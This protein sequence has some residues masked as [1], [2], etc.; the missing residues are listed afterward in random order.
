MKESILA[1]IQGEFGERELPE[2]GTV[3][4]DTYTVILCPVCN[5][6]TLDNYDICRYCGWEY[7]GF[8]ENHFP[9]ANGAALRDYREAYKKMMTAKKVFVGGSKSLSVLTQVERE[10]LFTYVHDECGDL[11]PRSHR[12][13][14][15]KRFSEKHGGDQLL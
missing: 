3:I 13:A 6:K 2:V 15:T 11:F 7:D 12:K 5:H 1:A 10:L 4:D 14:D 9:A 8:D